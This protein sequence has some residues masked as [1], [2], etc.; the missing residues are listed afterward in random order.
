MNRSSRRTVLAVT[1]LLVTSAATADAQQR[2]ATANGVVEGVALPSGIQ[3]FRGIPFAAPPVRDLRWREPQPVESWQGVRP[4]DRFGPQCMQARI[5]S[6]MVFRSD[7]TSEDCLYVNVWTP[8]ASAAGGLPVLVYFFGG[9]FNAGDGSEPRY[10]GE[11]MAQKGIVVVTMNYRLGIFGFFSHPELTRESPHGA[12]GNYGLMDQTAALRW[13]RQNIAAFGGDPNRVTLGGESAGSFSV[14]AQMAS[15]QAR[16]LFAQA[17]GQSG[18]MLAQTLGAQQRATTEQTGARFAES[19]GA[20]SLRQLR[21]LSSIE[22][23]DAAMR[24]GAPR[25]A[26]NVDGFF[27]PESPAAIYAEGRQARVPLLAGWNS[28]ERFGRAILA[29]PTPEN[30]LDVLGRTFSGRGEEALR[31]FPGRTPEEAARSATDLA[32][33]QFIN[34]ATWRWL[35]A[36]NRLNVPVYRYLFS[37]PRP[38]MANP[39]AGPQGGPGGAAAAAAAASVWNTIP[40]GA[41]H[42]AEIEYA[43]GNLHLNPVYAWTPEDHEVS[44]LFQE[45]FANFIRTGNP[46]SAGLPSWPEGSADRQGRAMRMRLDVGARAEPEERERFLFQESYHFGETA[47]R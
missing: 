22:L 1:A 10:D 28:E 11:S 5:Y 32:S 20:G 44:R 47:R 29:E 45:Y 21:A 30:W 36:Q 6:D 35:E 14:S 17:T 7:G 3:A 16:G 43:L 38:P 41:A 19:I 34:F 4:A 23:L 25:F 31:Y 13:V 33:D 2:V 42:A 9:G 18:A 12:S 15:P 40:R 39:Q 8:S 24:Q 37:R 27:F 46:N 26:P